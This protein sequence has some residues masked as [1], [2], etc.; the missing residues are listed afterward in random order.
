M[1]LNLTRS[2]PFGKRRNA[3]DKA[4]FALGADRE[5]DVRESRLQEANRLTPRDVC[6]DD[7]NRRRAERKR[8]RHPR[9]ARESDRAAHRHRDLDG[10]DVRCTTIRQNAHIT[11]VIVHYRWHPW[12]GLTVWQEK[13]ASKRSEDVVYA[14]R[15]GDGRTP[16]REIPAWMLDSAA[17]ASMALA[18][19]PRVDCRAL[20]ALRSLIEFCAANSKGGVVES[21][22]PDSLR[23][24]D[25]DA[26]QTPS[27]SLRPTR[28]VSGPTGE[29]PLENVA[30]GGQAA[31]SAA[32]RPTAQRISLRTSHQRER[33][34]G[35]R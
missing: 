8:P 23:K 10:L 7:A 31:G 35:V 30:A 25:A 17:C 29:T 11:E 1:P 12:H 19:T 32:A 3:L 20:R 24:G 9:V 2:R 4:F 21:Q 16:L 27:Q 22:H 18:E 15:D 33:K 5:P 14:S 6:S 34:G 28:P 26:N 13:T